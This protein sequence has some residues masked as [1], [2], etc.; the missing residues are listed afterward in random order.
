VFL[1]KWKTTSNGKDIGKTRGNK[2]FICLHFL[3][4]SMW[5]DEKHVELRHPT[6]FQPAVEQH[7]SNYCVCNAVENHRLLKSS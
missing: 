5:L 2:S 7:Q 6:A 3:L 1:K 4:L